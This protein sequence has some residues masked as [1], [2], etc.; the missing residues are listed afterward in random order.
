MCLRLFARC[1]CACASVQVGECVSVRA[2][3]VSL[4]FAASQVCGFTGAACAGVRA[5][6]RCLGKGLV[7]AKDEPIPVACLAS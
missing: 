6:I 5:G 4:A 2:G 1:V 3:G 7:R